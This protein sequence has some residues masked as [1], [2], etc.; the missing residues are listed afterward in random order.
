[1]S[2]DTLLCSPTCLCGCWH[3]FMPTDT[4]LCLLVRL[5]AY[6]HAFV[7][8]DTS[9]TLYKLQTVP[10]DRFVVN[11]RSLKLLGAAPPDPLCTFTVTIFH[12]NFG[13][14]PWRNIWTVPNVKH[15]AAKHRVGISNQHHDDTIRPENNSL[16]IQLWV[17]FEKKWICKWVKNLNRGTGSREEAHIAKIRADFN[18]GHNSEF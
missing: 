6:W 2:A 10:L 4:P 13:P 1:M 3:A 18:G 9:Q 8:A 7:P 15:S 16:K 17:G 5:C 11:E 14:S 12:Q